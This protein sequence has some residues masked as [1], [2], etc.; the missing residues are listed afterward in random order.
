MVYID[1]G[2]NG[3]CPCTQRKM[4]ANYQGPRTTNKVSTTGRKAGFFVYVARITGQSALKDGTL[5]A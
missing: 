5:F 2:I 3:T 1:H 4:T